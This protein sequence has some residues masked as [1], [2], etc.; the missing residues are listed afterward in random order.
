MIGGFIHPGLAL[1]VLLAAVP[2]I[3]HLLNRRR[4]RP[5]EWGAMRFVMAA[6]KRTRRR[7]QFEN[8]ILLLL[9]MAGI[10]LLALALARPF[11]G[12]AS[13]LAPLTESRRDV[14]LVVDVSAS[15]G[16]RS[17]EGTVF[18]AIV[19]RAQ[20]I[21]DE[22]DGGRG[23][24]ARLVVA[25]DRP[26][27]LS[28]RTPSEAASL[29]GAIGGPSDTPLDLVAALGEVLT[30]LES[31]GAALE[32]SEVEVLLLTDLQRSTFAFAGGDLPSEDPSDSD[33]LTRAL[34]R[35]QALGLALTVED[36][37]APEPVPPNV[38][39]VAVAP[40]GPV[41]GPGLPVDIAVDVTNFGASAV[42]G[43]RLALEVDGERLPSR[44]LD[45][46]AGA[47]A[48][49]L[50]PVTFDEDGAHRLEASI[51][52]DQLAFDDRRATVVD[53]PGTIEVLA[54]N[55]APDESA[56]EFDEVGLF[57]AALA[58]PDDGGLG[59]RGFVPF[60]LETIDPARLDAADLDLAPF[61]VI[62][63]A[64][65]EALSSRAIERLTETVA[66]GAGLIVTLG[67]R[68]VPEVY[69]R[70]LFA[71]DG[72][73]LLPAE[74][75]EIVA[76]ASRRDGYYR[77]ADFDGEH[78][79]LRFFSD[80]RW[81]PLWT[82]VPIYSYVA[83]RPLPDAR[84]LATLDSGDSPLLIE[85]AFDAGRVLLL[86]TTLDTNWNRIAESPRTLV[87][88]AH[89]LVRHAGRGPLRRLEVAVGETL[90]PTLERFPRSPMLVTP[91]GSRRPVDGEPTELVGG[92]WRL[93]TITATGRA[94][95]YTIEVDEGEPVVFAAQGDAS[96]G[97]LDRLPSEALAQ[98]HPSLRAVRA[99]ASSGEALDAGPR[100]ELWRLFLGLCLAVVVA[101]SLWSAWLE[102]RRRIA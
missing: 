54:V 65:V 67:D 9:R 10:A 34:D 81:Q 7:A 43:V 12:E 26:R 13:P 101:E 92:R 73:G 100:G 41:L 102:H 60:D 90:A 87:P 64:N 70:R 37:G 6:Y 58:P 3:I 71:A 93:P 29:L 61:D 30:S 8:L 2:L 27:L 88:F 50:F 5:L 32:A 28:W 36:L 85:R 95:L 77:V 16:Y 59:V 18:E 68:T 69:A 63:L 66:A 14:V 31:D 97:N 51:D 83:T 39:V 84:V 94:G 23:D 49:E 57:A 82:E 99:N 21:I 98:L 74:P 45:L 24:R 47:T 20:S 42:G 11:A 44:S 52:A 72:T 40:L 35:L 55:G 46:P 79:I 1:G 38:G 76:V 17:G 4:H 53:V 78:P 62:V 80:S 91:D 89:E 19:A 75:L 33:D 56:L 96:E 48:R 25:D 86:T 22:L 15:T